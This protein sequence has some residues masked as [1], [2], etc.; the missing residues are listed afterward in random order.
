[1]RLSRSSGHA[2][3]AAGASA[4][5]AHIPKF[6]KPPKKCQGNKFRPCV[7]GLPYFSTLLGL[8]NFRPIGCPTARTISSPACLCIR[9][10]PPCISQSV[11]TPLSIALVIRFREPRPTHPRAGWHPYWWGRLHK[12]QATGALGRGDRPDLR[13]SSGLDVCPQ[14]PI[15]KNPDRHPLLFGFFPGFSP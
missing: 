14:R 6:T 15:H 9:I 8:P 13:G 5:H 4:F 3:K 12:A 11:R 2:R 7:H 1:M 10:V